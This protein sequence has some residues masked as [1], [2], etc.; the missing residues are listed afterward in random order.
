MEM[1]VTLIIALEFKE[2]YYKCAL[3]SKIGCVSKKIKVAYIRQQCLPIAVVFVLDEN[4]VT[5]TQEKYWD[6][7]VADNFDSDLLHMTTANER[8]F[9]HLEKI[10]GWSV[11]IPEN[12][13]ITCGR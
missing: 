4:V 1:V 5:V 2:P 11:S 8:L 3:Y 6:T 12:Q 13:N 9:K 7:L 10:G